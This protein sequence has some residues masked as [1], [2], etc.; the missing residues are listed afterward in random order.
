MSNSPFDGYVIYVGFA[1]A[2]PGPVA[3]SAILTRGANKKVFT[4]MAHPNLSI[5]DVIAGSIRFGVRMAEG[6]KDKTVSVRVLTDSYLA[7]MMLGGPHMT[8][9]TSETIELRRALRAR[10]GLVTVEKGTGELMKEAAK[11]AY[12]AAFGKA[13]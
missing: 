12:E 13:P 11:A 1:T 7:I 9:E 5:D 2:N 6:V 4:E 8:G 10:E 3:F